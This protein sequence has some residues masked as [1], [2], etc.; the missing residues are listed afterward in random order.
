[1]QRLFE[2]ISGCWCFVGQHT[3][4]AS[5][6]HCHVRILEVRMPKCLTNRQNLSICWTNAGPEKCCRRCADFP[7]VTEL[8]RARAQVNRQLGGI[9]TV[10]FSGSSGGSF[11]AGSMPTFATAA[12]LFSVFSS[13]NLLS[14][15]H[16][17]VVSIFFFFPKRLRYFLAEHTKKLRRVLR[18]DSTK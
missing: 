15:C 9:Y 14:L 4:C 3:S 11:S 10:S 12:V 16:S 8:Y 7:V 18:L 13:A 1:M 2:K 17:R 5:C 6:Q